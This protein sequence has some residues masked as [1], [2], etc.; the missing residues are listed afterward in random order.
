LVSV[1]LARV[2]PAATHLAVGPVNI[3]EF[4][5][6]KTSVDYYDISNIG[7]VNVPMSFGPE[8][9]SLF[10]YSPSEPYNCG[11][12]GAITNPNGEWESSWAFSPPSVYNRWVSTGNVSCTSDAQCSGSDVCGLVNKVGAQNPF[13]L[14]CGQLLGFWTAGAVCG[15]DSSF[16]SP[17]NCEMKLGS[18]NSGLDLDNLYGCTG[19]G[20]CYQSGAESSCCGCVNWDAII[21]SDLSPSS[22]QQCNS[23]NPN[24]IRYVLPQIEWVK[25]GC[26][27]CYTFPYDDMS[28]TFVCSQ[29]NS[30][31]NTL[32][33]TV[34]LCPNGTQLEYASAAALGSWVSF[35][36]LF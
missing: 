11:T 9:G 5:L 28:S 15:L 6:A 20:S 2:A 29:T 31:L 12:P 16:G 30:K 25:M 36:A 24:W 1:V 17:F 7:G 32:N 13:Q 8:E 22:T 3:A 34:V 19:V 23:A 27:S 4:T 18:P 26:P 35:L 33:Y 14:T 10:S 21:G